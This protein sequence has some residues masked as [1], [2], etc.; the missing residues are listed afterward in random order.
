MHAAVTL[1]GRFIAMLPQRGYREGLLT[2]C[3]AVLPEI[4]RPGTNG[5]QC[6]RFRYPLLIGGCIAMF[7]LALKLDGLRWPAM[8]PRA[9]R[10]SDKGSIRPRGAHEV[11]LWVL[12]S[13][14]PWRFYPTI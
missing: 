10:L 5:G 11:S 14:L 4:Q 6:G 3:R 8:L 1:H 13:T 9:R 7:Q 12:S 2:L